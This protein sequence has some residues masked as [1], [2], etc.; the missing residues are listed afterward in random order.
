M[1]V[2]TPD[3]RRFYAR[4]LSIREFGER[5]QQALRQARVLV[6][7][8]GGLGCPILQYLAAAGVGVIGIV[9]GDK[10]DVSNLQR[11]ILFRFED[12]GQS[13]AR[14]A[15]A[16]LTQLNPHIEAICHEVWLDESN[17]LEII[18]GYDVIV[19]G[20]DNFTTKFLIND[21][22]WFA[23]K[24][25]VF[26]SIYQFEGQV[27]VFNAI[28]G[29]GRGPNYRDLLPSPPP[30]GLASNCLE[31]GVVGIVPGIIGCLQANEVIKLLT[32]IGETLSGKLLTFDAMD[33]SMSLLTLR[34]SDKNPLRGEPPAM[35]RL[36]AQSQSCSSDAIAVELISVERLRE[37]C[38]AG[39]TRLVDVRESGERERHS[40]G[41]LHV[42]LGELAGRVAAGELHDPLLESLVMYCE[43]GV[44][45]ASA[46]RRLQGKVS[47]ALYS[48]DGGVQRTLGAG[49]DLAL[50]AAQL[51]DRAVA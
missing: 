33:C 11:Q 3:E 28:D 5:G 23:G 51:A 15:A 26:G 45:S 19:D 7:G 40:L 49:Y 34:K 22:C 35:V 39:R 42:P 44:R 48:L 31:A 14:L 46:V 37:L 20:T 10:V 16:R 29:A 30:D 43:S 38:A 21:A 17:A 1:H 4:H 50:L 41:G 9:D 12:C 8:A 6:V 18:A 25:L 32:G 2:L 24:P 13:K 36:R 27:S 47:A